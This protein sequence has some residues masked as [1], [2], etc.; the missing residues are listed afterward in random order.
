MKKYS[1]LE[2]SA[3]LDIIGINPFVFVPEGILELLFKQAGKNKGPIPIKGTV[4]KKAY[5]QTLIKYQDAWRLYINTAMLDHSPK[6]V[7][8]TI[9]IT[10]SFNPSPPAVMAP[11]AFLKALQKDKKAGSMY[12]SL[13]P[14]LKKEILRYLS[15]LKTQESLDRNIERAINFLKGKERFLGRTLPG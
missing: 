5:T 6:R 9:A 3:A 15:H 4:N 7:G 1:S 10:V 14:S 12:E 13:T 8:E 2:F 11:P